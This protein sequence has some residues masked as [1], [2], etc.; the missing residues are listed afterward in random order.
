[1]DGASK[2]IENDNV[3]ICPVCDEFVDKLQPME[4]HVNAHFNEESTSDFEPLSKEKINDEMLA[5]ILQE[6]EDLEYARQSQQ[7]N[8]E[9]QKLQQTYGMCS[10][11]ENSEQCTSLQPS[12][13]CSSQKNEL[14]S[15]HLTSEDSQATCTTGVLES[16]QKNLQATGPHPR[17]SFHFCCATDHFSNSYFDRSWGCGYRNLQMLLS[18]LIRLDVYKNTLAKI[19][20]KVP[21]IPTIQ[22]WIE[23]AWHHGFDVQGAAQLGHKLLKTKKWIG[24]TEI[25]VFLRFIGIK[26]I[27][28]DFHRA[29][30][31]D[32][33]HPLM[34]DWF[35]EYFSGSSHQTPVYIQHQGKCD[36]TA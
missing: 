26:S 35:K 33:T 21:S 7:G 31:S 28:V 3:S 14:F 16:L 17:Y 10:S 6:E 13:K 32:G 11:S 1:M 18:A 4:V 25:A 29:T 2:V 19:C 15:F 9:F 12:Y 20:Q 23:N 8:D 24:A 22:M 27:I 34:Y 30:E 36:R 5:R